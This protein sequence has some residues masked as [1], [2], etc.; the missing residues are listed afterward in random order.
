[1]EINTI[2]GVRPGWLLATLILQFLTF[3]SVVPGFGTLLSWSL[4]PYYGTSL[5]PL[6]IHL[7]I[8][9]GLPGVSLFGIWRIQRWGWILAVIADGGMCAQALFQNGVGL[10][11]GPDFLEVNVWKFAA[12]AVLLQKPVRT[13]FFGPKSHLGKTIPWMVATRWLERTLWL[14][15]VPWRRILADVHNLAD[16]VMCVVAYFLAAVTATIA[17]AAFTVAFLGGQRPSGGAGI[18]FVIIMYSPFLSIPAFLFSLVL[19]I[20]VRILGPKRRWVWLVVG[21]LV[22]PGLS[23]A[24][25]GLKTPSQI[26]ALTPF[27]GIFPAWTCYVLYPWAFSRPH[28]IGKTILR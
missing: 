21:A 24:Y 13:Q 15:K 12:L 5:L 20:V 17:S 11:R 9:A 10:V 23:F 2:P 27:M 4:H 19:T 18:L 6:A 8:Y 1:M 25:L 16:R 28:K 26:L 14:D 7:S 3:L 22:G